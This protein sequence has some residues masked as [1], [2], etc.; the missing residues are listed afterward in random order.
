MEIR[1]PT[2]SSG[3]VASQIVASG[4]EA[5]ADFLEQLGRAALAKT[6]DVQERELLD[7]VTAEIIR[8]GR[9]SSILIDGIT[10]RCQAGAEV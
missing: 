9:F 4:P 3:E 8:R 10:G 6:N 2:I 7:Q 5:I 1:T